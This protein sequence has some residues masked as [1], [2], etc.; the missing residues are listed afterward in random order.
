MKI[1][2]MLHDFGYNF[3]SSVIMTA[4]TQL[5][6]YP[7]L[8]KVFPADEYGEILIIIGII[9]IVSAML[10]NTLN[11]ARLIQQNRYDAE[12]V[13][14]DFNIILTVVSVISFLVMIAV[15]CLYFGCSL[16]ESLLISIV[17]MLGVVRNYVII[18]YY[19][20]LDFKQIMISNIMVC[21]GYI[22]GMLITSVSHNW[23]MPFLLGEVFGCLYVAVTT[24]IFR[25]PFRCTNLL[26]ST[27]NKY[28]V[29]ISTSFMANAINYLDRLLIYPVLGGEMVSAYTVA[30]FWGKCLGIVASPMSVVLLG[31][32]SKKDFKISNKLFWK[33][34]IISCTVALVFYVATYKLSS[35]VT[36]IL[37]P[38][39]Y[40][41]AKPYIQIANLAAIIGVLAN[42]SNPIILKFAKAKWQMILQMVYG[43]VYFA[44]ALFSLT[45]YGI[46]GFCYSVIAANLVR[47]L[48]I[49]IV[50]TASIKKN[51]SS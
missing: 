2:K 14:G 10:G 21:I 4:V 19:A 26:F 39:L 17:T 8:A 42:L 45:R 31:Y 33:I 46:Y 6:T 50:G 27:I 9:N 38:T 40:E 18:A 48:L 34:N 47:L 11:N 35:I 22:I 49:Y 37:Y 5:I 30:A 7:Y 43:V 12:G 41:N 32:Y 23:T 20:V 28:A 3:L 16:T 13:K 29:L 25:E 15:C 24:D 44:L 51:Y 1:K 36:M